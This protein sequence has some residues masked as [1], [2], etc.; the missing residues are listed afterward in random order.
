M[1][2]YISLPEVKE[3][4]KKYL[5]DLKY[6]GGTAACMGYDIVL[7]R[8]IKESLVN[9]LINIFQEYGRKIELETTKELREDEAKSI[10]IKFEHCD[11]TIERTNNI[12]NKSDVLIIMPGDIGTIAELM[13]FIEEAKNH[14]SNKRIILYN[15]KNYYN[16]LLRQILSSIYSNFNYEDVLNYIDICTTTDE[17]V[18]KLDELSKIERKKRLLK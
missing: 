14:Y 8:N 9:E 5:S 13:S 1:K 11:S 4:D 16:K 6:I 7:G 17:I 15:H 10:Y 12:Y 18:K 3:V 2:L